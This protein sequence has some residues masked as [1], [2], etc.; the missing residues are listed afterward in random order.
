MSAEEAT[1][2][3]SYTALGIQW[4]PRYVP[5]RDAVPADQFI[6]QQHSKKNGRGF[7]PVTKKQLYRLLEKNNGIY[8][9]FSGERDYPRKLYADIDFKM[10]EE[11][12][13]QEEY[14]KGLVETIREY[15][16]EAEFAISGS[17]TKE[18]ASYHLISTN[19]KID[20][21]E[22]MSNVKALYKYIKENEN[23]AFDP[24]AMN[25]VQVLKCV[26]QSKPQ[27]P[28]QEAITHKGNLTA[29]LVL[30]G[31]DDTF[32]SI[33]NLPKMT[34]K[35][36]M[37]I[38]KEKLTLAD[39]TPLMDLPVPKEMPSWEELG[40]TEH[41]TTI[42]SF[43]PTHDEKGKE[44][45]HIHRFKVCSYCV[46]TGVPKAMF[47]KWVS[48]TSNVEDWK[49]T[50][51]RQVKRYEAMDKDDPTRLT[52]YWG[53]KYLQKFYPNL[54]PS[55]T[56]FGK[57]RS[58]F[59]VD[60]NERVMCVVEDK[61]TAETFDE[62]RTKYLSLAYPMGHGKTYAL[63]NWLRQH[64][65]KTFCYV[66]PRITLANDIYNRM[67]GGVNPIDVK[68]YNEHCGRFKSEK[69]E[70][71][72]DSSKT[73][74][75][76]ICL[77]SLHYLTDRDKMFDYIIFDEIE[78]TMTAFA[79]SAGIDKYGKE[80]MKPKIKKA[81]LKVLATL[82]QSAEK[83]IGMDA[84]L[85]KRYINL[86]EL[87]DPTHKGEH[88]VLN[89]TPREEKVRRVEQI[90]GGKMD[91]TLQKIAEEIAMGG[92]VFVF[93][94]YKDGDKQ[95]RS[96]ETTME[97]IAYLVR[98]K[99]GSDEFVRGVDYECYNGD[100]DAKVKDT[101]KDVNGFWG[102]MKLVMCN[103]TITAGVSYDSKVH[104]KFSSVY[105]FISGFSNPR[106]IA[107]VSMRCR[108][109][110]TDVIY[111]QYI[112]GAEAEAWED[113]TELYDLSY[114]TQMYKDT[115]IELSSPLKRTVELFFT[116]ADFDVS[117][118]TA[119]TL[120]E[121][122]RNDIVETI[123]ANV[124]EKS[125]ENIPDM[126]QGECEELVKRIYLYRDGTAMERCG[127]K[128][129][130]FNKLFKEDTPES[131]KASMWNEGLYKMVLMA[132]KAK[133][134]EKSFEILLAEA[135]EWEF[136]PEIEEGRADNMDIIVPDEA[137]DKMREECKG[138][139]NEDTTQL[140]RLMCATY[141][142]KYGKMI[143]EKKIREGKVMK[144]GNVKKHCYYKSVDKLS[145]YNHYADK[146]GKWLVIEAE[147]P[148]DT[149][150]VP[151]EIDVEMVAYEEH[152]KKEMEKKM[153]EMRQKKKEGMRRLGV[154]SN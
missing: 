22:Q 51:E 24:C 147:V 32:K 121:E 89:R 36:Q 1:R 106:D 154:V 78:T 72:G 6:V 84:F 137:R 87:I 45:D 39:D 26:G 104:Q 10:P 95:H 116:L 21:P 40:E 46:A 63:L 142:A 136:F 114:Y 111:T 130:S 57:F 66:V 82:F 5:W 117:Q 107:Q 140:V 90:K 119:L 123:E 93:Y 79:G 50:W 42:L 43:I 34:Q 113:D 18:K 96:M 149:L 61:L 4:S 31:I 129:Y 131:V 109:L 86:C 76:I 28:I 127:L 38:K 20:T 153:E 47:L 77:N 118:S 53:R 146:W 70:L 59:R 85:T 55:E 12:L 105:L 65:S 54:K 52:K 91:G 124:A 80:F 108:Q 73:R 35:A 68:L 64:P 100:T 101:L 41:A 112:G 94:P 15:F 144:N 75:L 141:N 103:S 99:T 97:I 25:N 88:I 33:P 7:A 71:L 139:Y 49:R 81:N 19:Y 29:H 150:T 74:N 115:I 98:E 48:K 120:D 92:K 83:V 126:E 125:W 3:V 138:R 13:N 143:I 14:I 132:E 133:Q 122:V 56:W 17:A 37:A 151:E 152:L 102:E 134:D 27:K 2:E 60:E 110:E 58:Q 62:Y 8:E 67:T 44:L 145:E 148:E 135:N 16:P 128:K 11:G 23:E 69:K 30:H 9:I